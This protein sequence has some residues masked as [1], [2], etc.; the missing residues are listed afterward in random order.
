MIARITEEPKKKVITKVYKK[1]LRNVDIKKVI[2]LYVFTN[3]SGLKM[4][5]KRFLDFWKRKSDDEEYA[6]IV[7]TILSSL[8]DIINENANIK[9][10]L[11][12]ELTPIVVDAGKL[13]KQIEGESN[14]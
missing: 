12:R 8:V 13:F 11:S 5:P 1:I 7:N 2:E 14:E 10:E 3:N 6:I 9:I 4:R